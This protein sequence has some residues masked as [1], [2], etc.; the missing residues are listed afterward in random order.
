MVEAHKDTIGTFSKETQWM[1][2]DR[3][4]IT[5][6]LAET[7]AIAIQE[8]QLKAEQDRIKITTLPETTP[9]A[10]EPL[11]GIRQWRV[12]LTPGATRALTLATQIRVPMGGWVQGL[13]PLNLPQ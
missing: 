1:V 11:S 3:V 2:K 9:G 7:I 4:E 10:E 8:A 13:G 5:N 12:V 6:D